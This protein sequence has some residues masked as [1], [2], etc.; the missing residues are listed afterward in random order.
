MP[1]YNILIQKQIWEKIEKE[2]IL[3][4]CEQK[5]SDSINTSRSATKFIHIIITENFAFV[6]L[7]KKLLKRAS[8]WT[9]WVKD[10]KESTG[11]VD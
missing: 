10:D 4:C 3:C 2:L 9:L 7:T 11:K 6:W 8:I 5:T 1:A